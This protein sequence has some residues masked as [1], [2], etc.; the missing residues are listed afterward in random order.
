MTLPFS[1]PQPVFHSKS[2]LIA[3]HNTTYKETQL[4][5]RSNIKTESHNLAYVY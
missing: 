4:Q 2:N 3:I 1:T 5:T